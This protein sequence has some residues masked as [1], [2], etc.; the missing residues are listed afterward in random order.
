M[1]EHEAKGSRP[2]VGI[3]KEWV[4]YTVDTVTK[5]SLA[6]ALCTVYKQRLRVNSVAVGPVSTYN[7][8]AID[9]YVVS[10]KTL[11]KFHLLSVDYCNVFSLYQW[12]FRWN[13][14]NN[15]SIVRPFLT[16]AA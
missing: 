10:V 4:R 8:A 1:H 13:K 2:R 5:D 6:L 3:C 7:M 16:L 15:S 14:N 9:H 12:D 11:V